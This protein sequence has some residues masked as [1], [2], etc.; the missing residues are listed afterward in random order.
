[1][2]RHVPLEGTSF[3]LEILLFLCLLSFCVR[4]S[5]EFDLGRNLLGGLLGFLPGLALDG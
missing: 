2:R 1:M 3:E 4:G 5:L